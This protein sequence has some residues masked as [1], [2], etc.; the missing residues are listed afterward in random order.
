MTIDNRSLPSKNQS[1][2]VGWR[3]LTWKPNFNQPGWSPP[4]KFCC[5]LPILASFCQY[6][7]DQARSCQNPVGFQ[8]DPTEFQPNLL[9]LETKWQPTNPRRDSTCPNR[10]FFPIDSGCNSWRPEVIWFELELGINLTWPNLWTTLITNMEI[11]SN[12]NG[13][14]K[15][16]KRW[17]K[18]KQLQS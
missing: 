7:P 16:L 4:T 15:I 14:F 12:L 8:Q 18:W 2:M 3:V 9:V 6:E 10:L 5:S 11:W 1:Q 17:P 13:Q